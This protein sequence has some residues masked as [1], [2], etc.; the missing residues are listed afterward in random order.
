MMSRQNIFGFLMIVGFLLLTTSYAPIE[1]RVEVSNDATTPTDFETPV[2]QLAK[3][4]DDSESRVDPSPIHICLS[5][6][7][8]RAYVVNQTS[9]SVSVLDVRARKIVGNIPVGSFP[10]H[11]AL[12][13]DGR[14]LLV[15]CHYESA[16][17]VIDLQRQQVV[18]SIP[19]G[20]EPYGVTLSSGGERIYVANSLSDTIS[21]IEVDSGQ[22]LFEVPVGRNPRFITEVPNSTWV[23]V[24]NGLSRNVSILDVATGRVVETRDLGR[25]GLLRQIVC[26]GD[27]K[28][29]L[30][31]HILSH[32]ELVPLQMERG[33]I[34]SNGFSVL[35][36]RRPAHRV[37]LLLDRLLVGAANPWGMALSSDHQRLYVS[38][39]GV[40][41]I[42]IVD[43]AGALQLVE[44]TNDPEAV[45]ALQ[46]N[47]QI[48]D[49]RKIVRRVDAGGIGPRGIA[50]CEATGELLVANYFSNTISVLDAESGEVRAVVPLG[51]AQEMTLWREGEMLFN[52]GR[53]CFQKWFSC[54]SCH[55]EDATVDGFNWDLPNDGT[56]NPKNVKSLHD[57]YDTPP[58]MWG[59]VR[60]GMDAAVA[61]GQRF[62]GFLP[63]PDN[64]RA[65]MA[66][67]GSPRRAPNPYQH[68]D[69]ETFGRGKRVFS[70]AR[71][72]A[73]HP[74]PLFTNLRK[75]DLDMASET[76]L[77]SRFDTPSLRECYRTA[78]YLHDGRA[79]TLRQIFTEHNPKNLHGLTSRLTEVELDDLIEYL[80]SL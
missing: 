49:E 73:C 61:A 19:T 9:N 13:S 6:D 48:L 58:A 10:T 38:L 20:Y 2:R 25:A 39:A 43:M 23:I 79:L 4:I 22:T 63:D 57:I 77:R 40:H 14:T 21:I 31:A 46:R 7:G 16:V 24:A 51:P 59:G 26:T 33:F 74:A 78:P 54:A 50:L 76:D 18:R 55:Q 1:S 12:S 3:Q 52:D 80:R 53:L 42:A 29:A 47:V 71:C 75:H 64:H 11:A 65:L 72:D 5:S 36:L 41:E 62:L 28:W 27:G 56:G 37:T 44:E 45:T 68:R 15:T 67:L 66:Y 60:K 69:A 34:H 70:K 32:D 35:N 30:V 8:Q 17:Q